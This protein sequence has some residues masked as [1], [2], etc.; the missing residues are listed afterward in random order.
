MDDRLTDDPGHPTSARRRPGR[1][2]TAIAGVVTAAGLAAAA[3]LPS[4]GT[5]AP[6]PSAKPVSGAHAT[7]STHTVTLPTGDKVVVGT[8]PS[9]AVRT[10]HPAA[11][12]HRTFLTRQFDGETYVVPADALPRIGHGTS[13]AQFDVSA[14][15]AGRA[16][17]LPGG[18]AH[19]NFPMHTATISVTDANGQPTD[20]TSLS[21]VNVDDSRKYGGFPEAVDGVAKIS[22]PDGHYAVMGYHAVFAKDEV[23][24]ERIV[25]GT[26]TVDGKDTNTS[27]SLADAKNQVAVQTP[28]P[29]DTQSLDLNWYR[30]SSDDM[31]MDSSV[32]TSD[33]HPVYL[34]T[35][36][37]GVGRQHFYVHAAMASPASATTPYLYDV[38][39]P[40][41]NVIGANQKYRA[42]SDSLAMVDSRYYSDKAHR[43]GETVWF[44][45]LPW[46][47]VVFRG[48]VTVTAPLHRT[49][50]VTAD[51]NL[52]YQEMLVA[53][54]DGPS[55]G[56]TMLSGYR[57]FTPGQRSRVDWLRGPIAPG[58]PAD[59]GI[60]PYSCGA[61]RSGDTLS[62][63]LSPMTDSTPDH[64]GALEPPDKNTVSTSH[65]RLYRGSKKIADR[66]DQVGGDF[67]VPAA[68]AS[69]RL[70]YDQTR[71]AP[72]TGQS[73]RSSTTWKFTSKHSGSTSVPKRW[74]C[75]ADGD[76][77]DCSAVPMLMPRYQLTEGLDGTVKP[78]PASLALT[79]GHAP[80]APE[81]PIEKATV[82]VSYDDG[83]TWT[84]T[85][86]AD[87]G[88][89]K[90]R[91]RW[92]SPASADG[93][94][95]ALKITA[96]D[97]DGATISQTVHDA[98][99]ITA[100]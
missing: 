16:G 26:F 17:R 6:A 84:P 92:T 36:P 4:T 96:T 74:A 87:L 37:S 66:K 65:F 35:S 94:N 91:A 79:I 18:D 82:S 5:A 61:C 42:T 33:D 34:S 52:M 85:R 68:S 47:S 25:F 81:V 30:G 83:A 22:V 41:D 76:G 69:Y 2:R 89:G 28:K 64:S 1:R 53:H 8:D 32:S 93:G 67:T 3:G 100:G 23:A 54:V 78:G 56:G 51:P 7:G 59:T 77:K 57:P 50:Y 49:E 15:V 90:F 27:L 86:L 39:F 46:E 62:I 99:T 58:I 44:G 24:S 12:T 48:G 55:V 10:A 29:A 95:A 9:G 97:A 38:E 70:V 20:D 60:G 40:S 45:A 75:G 73:T 88:A 63:G 13:L 43:A 80:G 31:G 11:A 21:V 14:L 19:P 72:W 71:T 98:F